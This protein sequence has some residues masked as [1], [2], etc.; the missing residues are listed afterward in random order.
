MV[1]TDVVKDRDAGIGDQ[2][3]PVRRVVTHAET[4]R[5]LA[6][7]VRVAARDGLQDHGNRKRP[8]HRH[9]RPVRVGMRAP[10]ERGAEKAYSHSVSTRGHPRR[11]RNRSIRPKRRTRAKAAAAIM[12]K[13]AELAPSA[14]EMVAR[15]LE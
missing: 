10:H 9:E 3:T 6:S 11:N 15:R 2:R 14:G 5:E 13:T 12:M 7:A 8:G 1:R 4:C